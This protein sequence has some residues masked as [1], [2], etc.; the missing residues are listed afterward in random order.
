MDRRRIRQ[1]DLVEKEAEIFVV[2]TQ[3]ECAINLV[4]HDRGRSVAFLLS[5][6][7]QADQ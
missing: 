2:V 5:R 6:P 1:S 7:D 3:D 4:G